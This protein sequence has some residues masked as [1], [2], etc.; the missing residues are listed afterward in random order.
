MTTTP[1]T[2]LITGA[3]GNLGMAVA[4]VFAQ[5]GAQLVLLDRALMSEATMAALQPAPCSCQ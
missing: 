1:R 4:Q 3:A 5:Q 2:I